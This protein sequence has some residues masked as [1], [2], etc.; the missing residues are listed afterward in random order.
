[1]RPPD[2]TAAPPASRSTINA[3]GSCV[4]QSGEL[5]ALT[6]AD[7][8]GLFRQAP[9]PMLSSLQT[10]SISPP[11]GVTAATKKERDAALPPMPSEGQISKSGFI[12][13]KTPAYRRCEATR[14]AATAAGMA[15]ILAVMFSS[16]REGEVGREGPE[17]AASVKGCGMWGAVRGVARA[18]AAAAA[19]EEEPDEAAAAGLRGDTGRLLVDQVTLPRTCSAAAAAAAR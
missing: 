11:A 2:V 15:A 10:H 19:A 18:A 1:V 6:R 13:G 12:F 4:L 17:A 9:S 7:I 16:Y 8:S 3:G 14:D 5:L